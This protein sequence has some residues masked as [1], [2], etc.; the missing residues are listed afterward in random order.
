MRDITLPCS[1]CSDG[2][3]ISLRRGLPHCSD[4]KSISLRQ[5]LPHCSV[6]GIQTVYNAG[7]VSS[8]KSV[9]FKILFSGVD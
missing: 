2:K 3:S 8:V 6:L 7:T 5:R 4:G 9:F 1:N